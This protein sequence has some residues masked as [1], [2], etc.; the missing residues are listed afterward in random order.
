MEYVIVH[1]SEIGTKGLN[2]PF[3]EKVL[4]RNVKEALE[5]FGI[6]KIRRFYGR[7]LI[8]LKK[9]IKL[10]KIEK[11]LKKIFGIAWFSFC[12]SCESDIKKITE[13]TLELIKEHARKKPTFKVIVQ[14]ADKSFPLTSLEVAKRVGD[15]VV[16]KFKLRAK[17]RKPKLSIFIEITKKKSFIYFKK[18]KGLYGMPVGSS[19]KVCSLI[20]GGIDSPVSSWFMLKRGCEIIYIHFHPFI[21]NEMAINSKVRKLIETLNEFN[22]KSEVYFIPFYPIQKALLK[23]VPPKFRILIFRRF[24]VRIAEKIAKE[25]GAYAIVTGES[26]GQVS[27]QTVQNLNVIEEATKLPILRPLIGLDKQE[28]IDIA[29]KIGTYKISIL[30]YQDCCSLLIAKHPATRAKIDEIKKI[31]KKIGINKIINQCLKL[32]R[33][34]LI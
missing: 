19:G 4:V 11:R 32:S 14:R 29:K 34:V 7:I 24:M 20:S 26:L 2:R 12:Y 10:K 17:M 23:E 22:R 9:D 31:E 16:K 27:S 28:I 21:K 33:V 13:K 5:E 15:E 1:Y 18:V 8:E 3:F 30:P 25:K 6:K